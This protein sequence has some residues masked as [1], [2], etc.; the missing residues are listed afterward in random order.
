MDKEEIARRGREAD[1]LLKN[2]VFK[3]MFNGLRVKY[4]EQWMS[5]NLELE[6]L[7]KIHTKA[8]LLNDIEKYASVFV[9]KASILKKD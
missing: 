3:E 4:F 1:A 7:E 2:E 9:A 6:E 8:M 5:P